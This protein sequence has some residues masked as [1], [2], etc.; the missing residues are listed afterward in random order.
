[1]LWVLLVTTAH[2]GFGPQRKIPILKKSKY[3]AKEFAE[4]F[5]MFGGLDVVGDVDGDGELTMLEIQKEF[6]DDEKALEL[7]SA[8]DTSQDGALD[9]DEIL[10]AR[11]VLFHQPTYTVMDAE[12]ESYASFMFKSIPISSKALTVAWT[13]DEIDEIMTMFDKNHDGK[14]DAIEVINHA[15]TMP[16]EPSHDDDEG[17]VVVRFVK[18]FFF[19]YLTPAAD[20]RRMWSVFAWLECDCLDVE[21][22]TE[23]LIT[24]THAPCLLDAD[25]DRL[26][27]GEKTS[28]DFPRN[29]N[30]SQL[31]RS[32]FTNILN[33]GQQQDECEDCAAASSS[34]EEENASEVSEEEEIVLTFSEFRTLLQMRTPAEIAGAVSH[35]VDAGQVNMARTLLV[36]EVALWLDD[37]DE[38]EAPNVTRFEWTP[39]N[40]PAQTWEAV[41]RDRRLARVRAWLVPS[42]LAVL[43]VAVVCYVGAVLAR[44]DAALK[45]YELLRAYVVGY[46]ETNAR[47]SDEERMAGDEGPRQQRRRQQRRREDNDDDP[48]AAAAA[49]YE[50]PILDLLTSKSYDRGGLLPPRYDQETELWQIAYDAGRAL[51]DLK[52]DDVDRRALAASEVAALLR[53]IRSNNPILSAASN[54]DHHRMTPSSPRL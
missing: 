33:Q 22:D 24:T 36:R 25:L 5:A 29:G 47:R 1:M 39:P 42:V 16:E 31:T 37:D 26:L 21:A 38:C 6:R 50:D 15:E 54:C 13:P 53:Q 8:L 12:R 2:A 45:D 30:A 11:R 28:C 49:D 4:F 14:I 19:G 51:A 10:A 41:L 32:Q 23:N 40:D 3:T 9:K 27:R 20:A 34:K 18:S 48:A 52:D 7:A 35:L 44:V 17:S 43:A 46:L